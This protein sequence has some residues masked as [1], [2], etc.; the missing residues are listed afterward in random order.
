MLVPAL[1]FEQFTS[2]CADFDRAGFECIN[3][4]ILQ[5]AHSFLQDHA[6]RFCRKSI[7]LPNMEFKQISTA[8]H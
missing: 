7:P 8:V 3:T 1:S 4:S 2:L 6:I 5:E